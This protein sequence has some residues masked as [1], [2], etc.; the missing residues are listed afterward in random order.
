MVVKFADTQREKEIKRLQTQ[1]YTSLGSSPGVLG[2]QVAEVS[3]HKMRYDII[4][5]QLL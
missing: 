2:M 3:H 4:Y 5:Y 1:R